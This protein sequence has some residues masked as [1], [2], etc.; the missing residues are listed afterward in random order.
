MIHILLTLV[1][2]LDLELNHLDIVSAFLNGDIDTTVYSK[3]P[4]GF[5][6]DDSLYCCLNKSL[7]SL[8]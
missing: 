8:C 5:V 1:A 6:I 4:Q 7:Y 2:I 3:Q